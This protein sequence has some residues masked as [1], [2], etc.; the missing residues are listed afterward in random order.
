MIGQLYFFNN[1]VINAH[2]NIA[3]VGFICRKPAVKKILMEIIIIDNNISN[4]YFYFL[5]LLTFGILYTI[6]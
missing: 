6:I 2:I 1:A 5:R 3:V 4:L